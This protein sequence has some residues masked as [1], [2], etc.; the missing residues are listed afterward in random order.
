[1]DYPPSRIASSRIL[2]LYKVSS[3]SNQP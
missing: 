3:L 1:M 2:Q